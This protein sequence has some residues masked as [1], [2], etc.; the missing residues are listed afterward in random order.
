MTMESKNS[1]TGKWEIYDVNNKTWTGSYDSRKEA[2]T[3]YG[4][5]LE[6][7]RN[8]KAKAMA[9]AVLGVTTPTT[10]TFVA[11]EDTTCNT[12]DS[13]V[14]F[15]QSE[16]AVVT[17][18]GDTAT[19]STDEVTKEGI[20]MATITLTKEKSFTNGAARYSNP[21]FRGSIY[22]G[23]GF[24]GEGGQPE[25]VT[26]D[27]SNLAEPN[28]QL[29]ERSTKKAANDEAKQARIAARNAKQQERADKAQKRADEAI[30]R[31]E[32]LKAKLVKA[33]VSA[34]ATGDAAGVDA[35]AAESEQV[36]E[37]V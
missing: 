11:G 22:V 23:A 33:P 26:L 14:S 6:Q 13:A 34:T 9:D 29:T 2:R 36:A 24:F 8:E 4:E 18:S 3:A 1:V 19:T 31:A 35:A 20:F 17:N 37:T 16:A 15:S 21:A 12:G 27:G 28:A 30:A 5:L 25:T 10:K 7:R 32:K